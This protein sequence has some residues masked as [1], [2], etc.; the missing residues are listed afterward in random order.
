MMNNHLKV[1]EVINQFDFS[2]EL[3]TIEPFGSG[4]I[5][6]TYLVKFKIKH[7][8]IVPVILQRMNTKIFINPEQ[9]MENILN[10]TAFLRKKIIENGGDPERETLTVILAKDG[11]PYCKDSDG[12]YWRAYH[13]IVGATGYDEV[14]TEEDFIKVV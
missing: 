4:H 10:V 1:K 9:L 2:G 8:G 3:F 13:F 5:N 12:D 7:M 14:R 6:D 11:K